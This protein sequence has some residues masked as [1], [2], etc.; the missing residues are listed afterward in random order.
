MA[1]AALAILGQRSAHSLPIGPM[2]AEPFTSPLGF[3]I[4]PALSL[5]QNKTRLLKSKTEARDRLEEQPKN[6]NARIIPLLHKL[7]PELPPK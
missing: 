6:K 3:T 7:S 1:L 5:K 2:I 4:T